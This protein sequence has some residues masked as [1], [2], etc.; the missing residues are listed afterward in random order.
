[1][2]MVD[3]LCM[4]FFEKMILPRR[5]VKAAQELAGEA[6]I[7]AQRLEIENKA[8]AERLTALEGRVEHLANT[9]HGR[10]GGR[11]RKV[12]PPVVPQTPMPLGAVHLFSPKE[13]R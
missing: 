4:A 1:M 7:R 5:L 10:L 6:Y 2:H 12:E 11:P 3:W 9:L 13:Q 8:L